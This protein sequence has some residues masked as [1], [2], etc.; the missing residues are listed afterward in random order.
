MRKK[1]SEFTLKL[2]HQN[3]APLWALLNDNVI[4]SL[5]VNK[6]YE[7]QNKSK[8]IYRAMKFLEMLK[9]SDLLIFAIGLYKITL[10]INKIKFK[11]INS[12]ISSNYKKIFVGH[13]A[14]AEEFIFNEYK[15]KTNNPILRINVITLEGL[16]KI[17]SPSLSV[18]IKFLFLN[19][20]GLSGKIKKLSRDI[21]CTSLD[22]LTVAALNI[23]EYVFFREFFKTAKLKNIDE[24]IFLALHVAAHSCAHEKL[25]MN[26]WSHG[27]IKLSIPMTKPNSILVIA[28]EEREYIK[29]LFKNKIKC[30][31]IKNNIYVD[32]EKSKS[33]VFISP[34][35]LNQ[36][37]DEVKN[38]VYSFIHWCDFLG[39]KIILRP[40]PKSSYAEL[41]D[42]K[43]EFNGAELDDISYD[44]SQRI[45]IIKPKFVV[46]FNSTGLFT[47]L[48]MGIIPIS[49]CNPESDNEIWNMIYPMR[50]R[51]LFW[52]SNIETIEKI[53]HSEEEYN[54]TLKYFREKNHK[55]F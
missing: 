12:D 43:N 28:K 44:F 49:F 7:W 48:K 21:N 27:L 16:E 52:R 31:L 54:S 39:I 15:E 11:N 32:G 18:L 45:K 30:E 19:S 10:S 53:I 46:G 42:L 13:G 50:D 37:S 41:L 17:F 1:I 2:Q 14:N 55:L 26:Y 23:A 47:A 35:I 33:I 5:A 36:F 3:V 8:K 34:E 4:Y 6:K 51:V 40:S 29:F 9:I 25:K 24:V 22:F 38:N 20:F